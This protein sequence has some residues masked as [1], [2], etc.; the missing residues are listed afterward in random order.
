M[1]TQ[2]AASISTI[3]AAATGGVVAVLH[4]LAVYMGKVS[5]GKNGNGSQQ[6]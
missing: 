4:A 5:N 2:L 3:I 1:T 6:S